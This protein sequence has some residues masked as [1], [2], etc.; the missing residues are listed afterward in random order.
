MLILM[1][2]DN[3]KTEQRFRLATL[4]DRLCRACRKPGLQRFRTALTRYRADRL[5]G[6]KEHRRETDKQAG[7]VSR[8]ELYGVPVGLMFFEGAPRLLAS[9]A[10]TPHLK[11][12]IPSA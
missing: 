11:Q 9:G 7:S 1:Q 5:V 6:D 3:S 12:V 10:T 2:L 4:M 8:Q